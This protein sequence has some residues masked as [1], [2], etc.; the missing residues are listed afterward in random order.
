V[1]T[2]AACLVDVFDTV[3]SIDFVRYTGVL[4]ERAGVDPEEFARSVGLWSQAAMD[5]LVSLQQVFEEALAGLGRTADGDLV[6]DLVAADRRLIHELTVLHDDAVPFLESL[7][8][9]SV[10]TAF[11]SNCA[12]NTRP[13]L[14]GLGLSGLVDELVL[15]CEVGASKPDPAIFEVALERLGVSAA[16]ALF[17]DDQ[18]AFVD[19]AATLGIHGVRIDR[20]NG[21]GHVST[22]A[23]LTPYF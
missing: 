10:R 14:D 20:F 4:A 3:V 21:A 19:A 17:V 11:V 5:G 15:S 2:Y 7:R 23:D 9:R 1:P 13:M 16:D 6:D 18:Q 12:E 8:E 22:L